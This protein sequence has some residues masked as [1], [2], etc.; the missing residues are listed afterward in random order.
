MDGVTVR[1]RTWG[2]RYF[3]AGEPV[4]PDEPIRGFDEREDRLLADH[5]R[6]RRIAFRPRPTSPPHRWDLHWSDGTDLASLGQPVAAGTATADD[7]AGAAAPS[8][9]ARNSASSN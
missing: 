7:V 3:P 2:T 4:T 6:M 8:P 1:L 5:P 9:A